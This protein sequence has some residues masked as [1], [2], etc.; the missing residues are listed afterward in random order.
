M[1]L[2]ITWSV[3]DFEDVRRLPEVR[4]ALA[5]AAQAIS[6]ACGDGYEA[7]SSEGRTR[8]RAAV[9]TTNPRAIRDN[10]RNNTLLRNIGAGRIS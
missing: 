3:P 1:A 10:A 2:K 9:V 8:S 4:D 5:D 7:E 6:T